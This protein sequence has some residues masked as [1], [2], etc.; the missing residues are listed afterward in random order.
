MIHSIYA[1]TDTSLYEYYPTKN[2]G[3]DEILDL[4][5]LIVSSS[6]Y[7]NRALIKFDLSQISQSIVS[8]TI[9]NP[10]FYL[11]IYTADIKEVP[12]QYNIEV[13]PVSQS[14]QTGN[15]R[16]RNQPQTV[17]GSSWKNRSNTEASTVEWT[18]S[19][20]N[21]N[22]TGGATGGGT[23]FTNYNCTQSYNVSNADIR[24]EI[25]SIVNDW[26]NGTLQNEGLIVKKSAADEQSTAKFET[27]QY[28]SSDSQTVYTPKLEVAWDNSVFVTGSLT[29]PSNEKELVLYTPNL[30]K[31]YSEMSKA[32]INLRVREKYPTITFATQSN[33]LTVNYLPTSSLYYSVRYADTNETVIPFDSTYTKVSCTSSGNFFDMWMG[34]LYAEKYYKFVFKVVR[35]G[36]EDYYDN[37]YIFKVIK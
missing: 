35:D 3:L 37:N 15:G 30:K 33:Y 8:G 29:Q 27:L 20:F 23:W 14:W 31:E 11:N 16:Y 12:Y 32:R 1:S 22:T 36:I 25:T 21:A 7:N 24:I 13:Y 18:T 28:F 9:T 34:G 6:L 17:Y 5:K 19:S 10:K 26:L 4:S 2:T